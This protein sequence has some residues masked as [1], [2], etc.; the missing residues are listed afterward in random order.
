MKKF[1]ISTIVFFIL[2]FALSISVLAATDLVQDAKNT[3]NTIGGAI[4]NTANSA[5]NV[6]AN[7]ENMVENG[8][9]NA[10]NT[11]VDSTR[12]VTGTVENTSGNIMGTMDNAN[13]NYTATRTATNTGLFG[14]MTSS[15]WTWV[16]LGI[17]GAAI[18]GL[19]WYYGAQYEHSNYSDGE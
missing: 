11:V 6:V 14:S 4:S 9:T 2:T 3:T 16:I 15:G 19:V 1:F 10:K 17:I 13:T 7:G 18:I 8:L 5:K 12:N